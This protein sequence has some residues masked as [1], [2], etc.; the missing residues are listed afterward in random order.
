MWYNPFRDKK[1][2]DKNYMEYGKY[3]EYM[4]KPIQGILFIVL[5]SVNI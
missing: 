2:H 3:M 5:L 1:Y 4:E